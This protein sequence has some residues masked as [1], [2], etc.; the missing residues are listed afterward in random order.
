MKNCTASQ[1][2]LM[3][4]P[5]AAACHQWSCTRL[6]SRGRKPKGRNNRIFHINCEP[7]SPAPPA[8]Y[9]SHTA[10][11]SAKFAAC[12][13]APSVPKFGGNIKNKAYAI[14]PK[15][16]TNNVPRI[17]RSILICFPVFI[18]S[19]QKGE[20][21]LPLLR[22]IHAHIGQVAIIAVIIE[23][24]TEH[25]L[26]GDDEAAVIRRNIALAAGGLIQQAG[27]LER[28]RLALL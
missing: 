28:S 19:M 8:V 24:I 5:T 17:A 1:S 25:E 16:A 2:M 11:P 20:M 12:R 6:N 21:L 3:S 26:V 14:P 13:I 15:Y 27:D 10:T 9:A 4:S 22:F 23:A 7:M 18:L